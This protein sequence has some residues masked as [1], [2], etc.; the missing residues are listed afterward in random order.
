MKTAQAGLDWTAKYPAIAIQP[1]AN[2]WKCIIDG[3]RNNCAFDEKVMARLT[4]L[5]CRQRSPKAK[6]TCSS[7]SRSTFCLK[8]ARIYAVGLYHRRGAIAQTFSPAGRRRTRL[9]F[10][11]HFGR[12]RGGC[13]TLGLPVVP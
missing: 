1:W 10:V 13:V 11:K 4:L 5:P 3:E 12:W 9:R 2:G 6:P 7:I 8:A